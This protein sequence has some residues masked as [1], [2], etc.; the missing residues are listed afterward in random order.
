MEIMQVLVVVFLPQ[1]ALTPLAT[2]PFMKIIQ[3]LVA[4][5]EHHLAQTH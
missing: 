2:I 3:V 5:L 1:K 4:G